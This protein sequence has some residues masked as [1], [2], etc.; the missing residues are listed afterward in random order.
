MA[1]NLSTLTSATTS[2]DVLSELITKADFLDPVP[3]LRNLSRSPFKG[4]DATQTTALNQPKALPLIDGKGYLYLSGV[5]GNYASIP[6]DSSLSEMREVTIIFNAQTPASAAARYLFSR[7]NASSYQNSLVIE[8]SGGNNL[9]SFYDQGGNRVV[10][11]T[12]TFGNVY[13]V[14]ITFNGTAVELFLD[15]VSVDTGT[16]SSSNP[17]DI[18]QNVLIGGGNTNRYLTG[19]IKSAV[20]KNASGTTVLNLDV[21]ATSIPHGA[22]KFQCATGQTVT[23]NQ[24]GNDPATIIKRSVLRFN[25]SSSGLSGLFNQTITGGHFFAAFSVLGD[26]GDSSGR[27]FGTNSTGSVDNATGGY[28]LARNGTSLDIMTKYNG[29]GSNITIHEDVFDDALGDMLIEARLQNG[30][31]ISKLNNANEANGT[32]SSSGFLSSEEFAI[33]ERTTGTSNAAFDLEYLAV[34]P[35]LS[36]AEA[37]RVVTYINNRNHVFDLKDGFGYYTYTHLTLP[38]IYSV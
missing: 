5:T 34:F 22:K 11:T 30:S 20:A 19:F 25:G 3:L 1:L 31:Q 21:N 32:T 16:A 9:I 18:S 27:I 24:S 8:I 38:T 10:T 4:G 36:D 28:F 12:I 7:P 37:A 14:K 26:G 13:T 15:G 2:G 33:A 29:V 23:I 6:H 35:A 17:F